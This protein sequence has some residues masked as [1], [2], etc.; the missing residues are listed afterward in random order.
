MTTI[1]VGTEKGGYLLRTEEES[2]HITGPLFAGWKVTA[3][4][5]TPVG[6]TLAALASNWFGAS[7][8]R[9]H[10]LEDWEQVENGPSYPA[11]SGRKLNQIWTFS[12][13]GDRILA[14]VD[15]AGLFESNDDGTTWN[16]VDGLNEHPSRPSWSPGLG[17]LCA[18]HVVTAGERLWVGISAVGVFRSDDGGATF[19][20][21][22]AGVPTVVVDESEAGYCVHSIVNDPTDPD[23]MWRQDHLGVFRS[24]DGGGSWNR[25]EQGLPS[26][27]GFPM[28]RDHASGRL[29]IVPLQSD[30]NRLPVDGLFRVYSSDDDGES[31]HVSGNGWPES[32]AYTAVLRGAMAADQKGGVYAGTT[33][34]SIWA[35]ADAGDHWAELPF[36]LPRI[37]TVAVIA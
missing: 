2:W 15:E 27:F 34:G 30:E 19:G 25:I 6:T 12:A 32:A 29:F 26:S 3:W 14:G 20:R 28:V 33:S 17:G 22:D 35:T 7:I 37:L 1:A 16:A 9:S 18:H 10:N 4:G 31:W 24:T 13:S 11:D 36:V 8:H 23:R 21:Y 5:T